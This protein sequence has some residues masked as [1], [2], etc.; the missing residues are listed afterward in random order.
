MTLAGGGNITNNVFENQKI[1]R[2]WK[3]MY[4]DL[5]LLYLSNHRWK[6]TIYQLTRKYLKNY[7]LHQRLKFK[8]HAPIAVSSCPA[9]TWDLLLVRVQL[10]LGIWCGPLSQHPLPPARHQPHPLTPSTQTII[11]EETKGSEKIPNSYRIALAY[12]HRTQG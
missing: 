4:C 8:A 2:I 7:E 9:Y 3:F 10:T 5:L 12:V 11:Q 6:K 1:W